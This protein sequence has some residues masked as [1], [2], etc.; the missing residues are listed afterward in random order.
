MTRI[1]VGLDKDGYEIVISRKIICEIGNIT[2]GLHKTKKCCIVSQNNIFKY[3]GLDLYKSLKRAGYQVFL[4]LLPDGEKAKSLDK[5]SSLYSYLL[6]KNFDRD[7]LLIALGGGV[8]GDLT[9]FVAATY[10]RGIPYIQVPT[11]LL[12]S[13]DSSVGGK[14]GINFDGVKNI[15]GSFYQPKLVVV[16]IDTFKTLPKEEFRAGLGE[17]IKYAILEGE[18]FFIE[19]ENSIHELSPNNPYLETIIKRCCKNKVKIVEA[20]EKEKKGTRMLL[21]LGHTMGHSLEI[22]TGWKHGEAVACGIVFASIFSNHLGFLSANDLK[23]IT[24]LIKNAGLPYKMPD[25]LNFKHARN[26]I[27]KDKKQSQGK[28]NWV[29]PHK[30]GDVRIYSS[31]LSEI[32]FFKK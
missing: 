13:I 32:N 24:N 17:V 30:I 15:V 29:L 20:D 14:T 27:N 12:S 2:S 5:C 7:S 9:G 22:L 19:L 26:L 11:T 1:T 6:E 3:Y 18:D 8:V 31:S 21:N 28:I 16:D 10:M 4:F 25:N 23:R